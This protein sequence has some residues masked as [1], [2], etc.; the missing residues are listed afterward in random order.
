[1]FRFFIDCMSLYSWNYNPMNDT[2][3]KWKMKLILVLFYFKEAIFRGEI[4]L[5]FSGSYNY[6]SLWTEHG[7]L[8]SF[9]SILFTSFLL[10]NLKELKWN[11]KPSKCYEMAVSPSIFFVMWN[12]CFLNIE[13][14][15]WGMLMIC[16]GNS[17]T[18]R[19]QNRLMNTD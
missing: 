5:V 13:Y 12:V 2:D 10:S 1:M 11:R 4:K 3:R 6:L 8:F 14:S 16:C 15:Y 18:F 17:G 19:K 7:I 9:L